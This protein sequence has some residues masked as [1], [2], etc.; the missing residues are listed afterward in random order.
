MSIT[1]F[2]LSSGPQRLPPTVNVLTIEPTGIYDE[3]G[4]MKM[5]TVALSNPEPARPDPIFVKDEGLPVE[6]RV[7]NRWI[8]VKGAIGGCTLQFLNHR[9]LFLA[10]AS[11][12]AY[13]LRFSYTGGV[14]T[15]GRLT[16][17]C[18]LLPRFIQIRIPIWFRRWSGWINYGP[19]SHWRRVD[20]ELPLHVPGLAPESLEGR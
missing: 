6:V 3:V 16:L 17:L 10:P 4:E 8:V 12:D 14:I 15:K 9:V 1:I 11:A 13:R 7:T 2:V 18:G 19:A 5:V 20:L